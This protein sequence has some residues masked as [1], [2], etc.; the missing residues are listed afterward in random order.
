MTVEVVMLLQCAVR[1]SLMEAE[2]DRKYR[3]NP[4]VY[5]YSPYGAQLFRRMRLLK[6]LIKQEVI[7]EKGV[8][9][10]RK[11]RKMR[12][13]FRV[14]CLGLKRFGQVDRKR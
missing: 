13:L 14:M 11:L 10:Q 3:V 9:K 6:L 12:L 7:F 8:A 4:D 5:L 2:V 1:G